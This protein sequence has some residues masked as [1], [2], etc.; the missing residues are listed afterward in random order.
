MSSS[1]LLLRLALPPTMLQQHEL[2]L[3]A[4][5]LRQDF[6]IE[7]QAHFKLFSQEVDQTN[8]KWRLASPG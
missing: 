3:F 4:I 1:S 5:E 6:L 2:A 8:L 7:D